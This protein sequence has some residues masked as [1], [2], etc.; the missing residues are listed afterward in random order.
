MSSIAHRLG[1]SKSEI[2]DPTSA[3]AAVVQA[4][5]ETNIIQETKAYFKVNGID[6]TAFERKQKDDRIILIKNFPFGTRVD[7]LKDM[8]IEFGPVNRV[9]MP[10]AGTIAVAEFQQAPHARAAFASLAYRRF[11]DSILFL[12]KGPKDLFIADYD[13]SKAL[14]ALSTADKGKS[15]KLSAA[16]LLE[17]ATPDEPVSSSSLYVRNLSFNTTQQAFADLFKPLD[18]FLTARVKTKPDPKNP[19]NTLSMG[20]G[21]VEFRTKEQAAIAMAALNGHT[22]DGHQLAIKASHKGL[23]AV[24]ERKK[25]EKNKKA[26]MGRT[27]LI[28]K[29][30]PFEATK[31]DV[32]SLFSYVS[33]APFPCYLP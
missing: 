25:D 7:E 15:A 29:N 18:G 27:K 17:A 1:V 10:P 24:E 12:E 13:P 11:K 6:L 21:F 32:M 33:S 2:L 8:L 31:K 16:E 23:D 9:L 4:H 20:F 3:D 5:A 28:V 19:G 30:L 26:A 14:A 22:L